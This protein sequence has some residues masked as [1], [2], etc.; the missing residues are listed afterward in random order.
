MGPHIYQELQTFALENSLDNLGSPL[1]LIFL[2]LLTLASLCEHQIKSGVNLPKPTLVDSLSSLLENPEF[3]DVT[4]SVQSSKYFTFATTLVIIVIDPH[5][6]F[7]ESAEFRCHKAI[8]THRSDFFNAMFSPKI[9]LIESQSSRWCISLSGVFSEKLIS[10]LLMM[11]IQKYSAE[12]SLIYILESRMPAF[13][14]HRTLLICSRFYFFIHHLL[15]LLGL[16][17]AC[18]SVTVPS[19]SVLLDG[20]HRRWKRTCASLSCRPFPC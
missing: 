4:V 6:F 14:H 3:S 5:L 11:S 17:P 13:S 7:S 16:C 18:D 9:A 19:G 8:L 15:S 20:S 1:S 12:F 2:Y 10:A